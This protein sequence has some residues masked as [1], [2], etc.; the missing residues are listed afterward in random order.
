MDVFEKIEVKM[1]V[2]ERDTKPTLKTSTKKSKQLISKT[3]K[4][5]KCNPCQS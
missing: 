5:S 3:K 2:F 4:Q 1:W